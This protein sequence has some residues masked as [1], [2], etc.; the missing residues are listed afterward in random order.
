MALDFHRLDNN[1]YLFGLND[2]K[3]NSLSGILEI[4][5][6]WTGIL[7][8]QYSDAILSI[9]NQITLIKIIDNYV[10]TTNLNQDK[11]KTVDIL[12][13]RGL[14]TFFSSSNCDLKLIG[15]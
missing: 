5:Q 10:D 2:R 3:Y 14:L 9:E 11:Q 15:D 4:Y 8:S 12:E 13:F 7:I 1:Q 6:H